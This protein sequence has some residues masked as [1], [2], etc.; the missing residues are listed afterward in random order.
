MNFVNKILHDRE[1]SHCRKIL[2]AEQNL[3]ISGLLDEVEEYCREF[4]ILD[5]T[6]VEILKCHIDYAVKTT[7][8]TETWIGLTKS[9]KVLMR[10]TPEKNS[11]RDYFHFSK[12]ESKLVFHLMVGELN[13]LTNKKREYMS[14]YGGTHCLVKVCGGEDEIGD[15]TK[16]LAE[17]LVALNRERIKK[18]N[19]PLIYFR[20]Y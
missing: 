16:Q 5:V 8:R 6:R 4:N 10:W 14:R 19:L 2:L 11:N 3:K 1:G 17:Y 18:Y 20:H 7:S 13:L 15:S 9:S 12:L